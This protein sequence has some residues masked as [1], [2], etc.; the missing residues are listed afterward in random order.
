LPIKEGVGLTQRIQVWYSDPADKD[1]PERELRHW[2]D[3]KTLHD[4]ALSQRIGQIRNILITN[5]LEKELILG[6]I[7]V[8]CLP[9]LLFLLGI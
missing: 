2:S 7:K 6:E 5:D 8:Q 9:V 1:I 3:L 4:D